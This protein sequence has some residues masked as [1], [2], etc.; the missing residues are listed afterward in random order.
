MYLECLEQKGAS[1]LAEVIVAH[2]EGETGANWIRVFQRVPEHV[3]LREVEHWMRECHSHK[4]CPREL[5]YLVGAACR[6]DPKHYRGLHYLWTGLVAGAEIRQLSDGLILWEDFGWNH[7]PQAYAG[8][9][10]DMETLVRLTKLLTVPDDRSSGSRDLWHL[11][12]EHPLLVESLR[13][14]LDEPYGHRG[15]ILCH[16][17]EVQY[18]RRDDELAR[19]F[20]RDFR[21]FS[22]VL[23]GIPENYRE[24]AV[25]YFEY[26]YW[27]RT[28][29]MPAG[30]L[31]RHIA[32]L[33][34]EPFT[35]S[36][37]AES[38]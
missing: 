33:C 9:S 19:E 34:T 2:C 35:R 15:W 22:R 4:H 26:V 14:L 23:L 25:D 11:M 27:D 5:V 32:T 37:E 28:V 6:V 31:M 7:L 13:A 36:D 20:N 21:E 10:V 12:H 1:E 29:R 16:M 8:G 30:K 3:R 38:L 18:Y 17:R 24:K